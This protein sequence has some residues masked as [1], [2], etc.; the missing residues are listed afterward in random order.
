MQR[1][2][3]R[4][5]A[6]DISHPELSAAG[7]RRPALLPLGAMMA[8]VALSGAAHAQ[9]TAQAEASALP[10]INVNAQREEN[11]G[12]Q[13]VRTTV[14]KSPQLLRDVPQA[15]T[16]V[17][18]QLIQDRGADTLKEALRNVAGLTF[19]AGEGGRIGDN[20]TLRGYSLVGDLYLDGMR[21]IAQYNRE[22]FNV[23]QVDVLRG[24]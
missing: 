22:V 11:T 21:D 17:T 16:V 15:V 9:E 1:P 24:S 7:A 8:A 19:N 10:A 18:E 6:A 23:E 13:G 20:I 4:P 3:L 5:L 2:A 14:G 12:Y